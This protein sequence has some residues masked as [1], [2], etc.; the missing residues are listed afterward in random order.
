MSCG[1]TAA[2]ILPSFVQVL[3]QSRYELV[4]PL[5]LLFSSALLKVS[6]CN[7]EKEAQV[8]P[9]CVP[10][11]VL[12]RLRLVS[13]QAPHVAPHDGVLQEAYLLFHGFL[14][15]PEPCSSASKRLL[16]VIQKELRAP[17]SSDTLTH[18]RYRAASLRY[19]E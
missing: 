10:S 19:R 1:A 5:T 15:W 12:S 13:P 8:P 14:T 7:K 11:L 4:V 2:L 9:T 3:E 18:R 17:G 16:K 6:T